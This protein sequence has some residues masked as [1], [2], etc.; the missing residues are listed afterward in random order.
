MPRYI[1][2]FPSGGSVEYG[3]DLS[4]EPEWFADV[5]DASGRTVETFDASSPSYDHERPVRSLLEFLGAT[6]DLFDEED[7]QEATSL[8]VHSLLEDLPDH[9]LTVGAVI[10]NLRRAAD[11]GREE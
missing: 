8:L 10:E 5:L 3:I 2:D 11:E 9:L 4:I 7:V 6:S 1:L